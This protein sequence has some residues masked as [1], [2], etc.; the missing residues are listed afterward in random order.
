ME[1]ILIKLALL[2]IDNIPQLIQAVLDTKS[3]QD[4]DKKKLLD[5][6]QAKL[7]HRLDLVKAVKFKDPA[8]K[9][10]NGPQPD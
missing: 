9:V 6:L 7:E 10:D 1:T 2:I 4:S 8:P 5:E 3:L